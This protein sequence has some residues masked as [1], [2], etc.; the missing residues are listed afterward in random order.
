V[1]AQR[2]AV[3]FTESR[4]TQQYLFD[5]LSRSGY[6]GKL[7]MMN[8]SNND[9]QS[10]AIYETWR[11]RQEK[12]DGL[13]GSRAVDIKAAI[14]EHFRDHATMRRTSSETGSSTGSTTRPC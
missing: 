13:T 1:G 8:G 2:K 9:P 5:L 11:A 12:Q 10:K 6:D 14:V 4:R 3:L 7:V